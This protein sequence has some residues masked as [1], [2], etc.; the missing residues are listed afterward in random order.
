MAISSITKTIVARL[1]VDFANVMVSELQCFDPNCVP[2][3]TLIVVLKSGKESKEGRW[4]HKVLKPVVEV[5]GQDIEE[6]IAKYYE[7]NNDA[8]KKAI[9][10]FVETTIANNNLDGQV[11]SDYLKHLATT[12]LQ[13][14]QIDGPTVKAN[15]IVR[16]PMQPKSIPISSPAV[17]STV[18]SCP[19]VVPPVSVPI[20]TPAITRVSM[21]KPS[22]SETI[23]KVAMVESSAVPGDSSDTTAMSTTGHLPGS[24]QRGC[25]C[26]DPDN[27]D[28]II[29]KMMFMDKI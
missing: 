14:S 2:I 4:V 12:V 6:V 20:A 28:N 13:P 21:Q 5:T 3:E 18:A 27:L 11:V 16:V 9:R 7:E 8:W 15:E 24:R 25:P 23:T 19:V 17:A 10:N 29:D 22:T 1:S 26:C